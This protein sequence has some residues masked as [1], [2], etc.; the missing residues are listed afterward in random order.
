MDIKIIG[1]AMNRILTADNDIILSHSRKIVDT[2]NRIIHGYD[3]VSDEI[4]W[5]IAFNNLPIL[6]IEV[7]KLLII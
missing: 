6:K 5:N 2:R 4:I 3:T 1:E 7:E